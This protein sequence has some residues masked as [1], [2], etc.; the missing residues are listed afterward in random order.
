MH[1][2]LKV[3]VVCCRA[4]RMLGVVLPLELLYAYQAILGDFDSLPL[5]FIVG[6]LCG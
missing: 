5:M 6:N 2:L 3:G 1:V 4:L